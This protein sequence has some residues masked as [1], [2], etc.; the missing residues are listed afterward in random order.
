MI[1]KILNLQLVRLLN[2]LFDQAKED[3]Q[4]CLIFQTFHII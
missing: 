3:E 2:L 4:V 1:N